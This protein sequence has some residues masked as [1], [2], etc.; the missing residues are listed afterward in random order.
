MWPSIALISAILGAA[1]IA[2]VP[3]DKDLA[4]RAGSY[5]P[6]TGPPG[7]CSPLPVDKTCGDVFLKCV[8]RQ[9][10]PNAALTSDVCIAAAVCYPTSV[11]NFLSNLNCRIRMASNIPLSVSLPRIS[12]TLF[13]HISNNQAGVTFNAFQVWYTNTVAS[14]GTTDIVIGSFVQEMYDIISAWSGFCNQPVSTRSIPKQ[15]F[16]NWIQYSST[17]AGPALTCGQTPQQPTCETAA[18]YCQSLMLSCASVSGVLSDPFSNKQCVS[19]ATCWPTGVDKFLAAVACKQGKPVV[20]SRNLPRLSQSLFSS[21]TGG[22]PGMSEQNYVDFIYSSE[23]SIDPSKTPINWPKIADVIP[24]W[25][26]IVRWT[27]FCATNVVPYGNLA[28]WF[29]YSSSV[30]NSAPKCSTSTPPQCTPDPDP[31][32]NFMLQGCIAYPN[33]HA[34]FDLVHNP[35]ASQ[36]CVMAATCNAN[37]LTGFAKAIACA[38]G[39]PVPSPP[40]YTR[41]TQGVFNQMPLTNGKLSA[42]NYVDVFYGTLTTLNS[43]VWPTYAYV[44]NNYARLAAWTQISGDQP[45]FNFAD[46]LQWS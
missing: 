10:Q 2:A 38:T 7:A 39:T 37:G 27:G 35:F 14:T 41:L 9:D 31:S 12:D 30:I 28:D 11:D 17:V 6:V 1:S 42:Q 45:Y 15:N 22:N 32:C 43:N 33:T 40:K 3:A 26:E 19:A 24:P 34:G 16:L 29:Q 8:D 20:T 44:A 21:V 5:P 23:G 25:L 36:I 13:N 18:P 46:W 4:P